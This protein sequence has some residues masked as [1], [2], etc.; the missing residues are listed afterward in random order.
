[1]TSL[2]QNYSLSIGKPTNAPIHTSALEYI[3][4]WL[5][6]RSSAHGSKMTGL[7]NRILII[8]AETGSGKSTALPYEIFKIFKSASGNGRSIYCTQPKVLT[9]QSIVLNQM[10]NKPYFPEVQLSKN[11]GYRTGPESIG[12]E[13]GLYYY[14]LGKLN[15]EIAWRIDV[16]SIEESD[17][18]FI[19]ACNVLIIDEAHERTLDADRFLQEIFFLYNRNKN[20]LN[21]PFLL[22]TS[23]TMDYK[24]LSDYFSLKEKNC[25]FIKG[26]Q[27]NIQWNFAK[28]PETIKSQ[29][30]SIL[31][32]IETTDLN[33]SN[34]DILIFTPKFDFELDAEIRKITDPTKADVIYIDSKAVN[35]KTD[36]FKLLFAETKKRKIIMSTTVAETGLTLDNL[37]Y[38]IDSGYNF[39][40]IYFPKYN[41]SGLVMQP[42]T[43][44][45]IKQRIGRCG[46][47]FDGI[48]YLTYSVEAFKHL[49]DQQYP[50]II[51]LGYSNKIMQM[52]QSYFKNRAYTGSKEKFDYRRIGLLTNP[53]SENI[54]ESFTMLAKYG[55][56]S[57]N[58]DLAWP[59][60]KWDAKQK[61]FGF[62][63]VGYIASCI[64]F[65]N[66]IGAKILLDNKT[67]LNI[68]DVAT[69]ATIISTND[70]TTK[71]YEKGSNELIFKILNI[72]SYNDLEFIND[73][74]VFIAVFNHSMNTGKFDA[75]QDRAILEFIANRDSVL[76]EL[77]KNSI[78]LLDDRPRIS[79]KNYVKMHAEF[80]KL[81]E[82]IY[83]S[84]IF[85]VTKIIKSTYTMY[86]LKNVEKGY[87]MLSSLPQMDK[88]TKVLTTGNIIMQK[89]NS[90]DYMLKPG[91]I[92]SIS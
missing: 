40:T 79:D 60:T 80:I 52:L 45:K 38:V 78:S 8:N 43:K 21:L 50:E 58:V 19:S 49:D 48:G 53:L 1:M 34:S 69:I 71:Y 35:E 26:R 65:V 68:L 22:F 2:S 11:L 10:A 59:P 85:T 72:E 14:T 57:N 18:K 81:L 33:L 88:L 9:A 46:R 30:S 83:Y 24:R 63:K 61:H 12:R 37:K 36:S 13:P 3:T 44:S 76:N 17:N 74:L 64:D 16:T 4:K 15:S 42:T 51:T 62:T 90:L 56:I 7:E 82:P 27:F 41:A 20:N 66:I 6:D 86:E 29:I 54:E 92:I 25:L 31:K 5:L 87:T 47:K 77:A 75:F 32:K 39:S 23:A 28:S 84:N 67:E 73:I 89:Q 55:F 70:L 91:N